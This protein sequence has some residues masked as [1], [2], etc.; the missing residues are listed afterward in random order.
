MIYDE[1]LEIS[2]N[3]ITVR[4]LSGEELKIST[5]SL[6]T[7][8]DLKVDLCNKCSRLH[9]EV[10]LFSSLSHRNIHRSSSVSRCN[11]G[12]FDIPLSGSTRTSSGSDEERSGK[13]RFS[14]TATGKEDEKE[15]SSPRWNVDLRNNDV[16]GDGLLCNDDTLLS[17]VPGPFSVIFTDVKYNDETWRS[18]VIQHA[19]AKDV[20]GIKRCASS[21]ARAGEKA[22]KLII[23]ALFN[24]IAEEPCWDPEV[25]Q[26]FVDSKKCNLNYYDQ[27][28]ETILFQVVADGACQVHGLEVLDILIKAH[29]NVNHSSGVTNRTA[30]HDACANGNLAAVNYLLDHGADPSHC[31]KED[32]TPAFEALKHRAILERLLKSGIDCDHQTVGGTTLLHCAISGGGNMDIINLLIK[33]EADVNIIDHQWNTN[34]IFAA[35]NGYM[36]VLEMLLEMH[37]QELLYPYVNWANK[38]GVTA[39]IAACRCGNFEAVQTLI[40]CGANVNHINRDGGNALFEAAAG[41]HLEIINLLIS[42]KSRLSHRDKDGWTAMKWAVESSQPEAVEELRRAGLSERSPSQRSPSHRGHSQMV[43]FTY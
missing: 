9:P 18:T 29:A 15:E 8:N 21:M 5:P 36:D 33:A 42:A 14:H 10:H 16:S 35:T 22:S 27:Y 4:Y 24:Y 34:L 37:P 2:G 43:N 39:L 26:C 11:D 20:E 32:L 40:D 7:V 13:R 3:P 6:R 25:V 19:K 38:K 1:R 28:G 12:D 41:G 30:L 31:T 17:R 23:E